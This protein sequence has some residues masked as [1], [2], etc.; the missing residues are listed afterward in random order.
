MTALAGILRFEGGETHSDL[1]RMLKSQDMYGQHSGDWTNGPLSMG[2]RLFRLLPEDRRDLGP[3]IGGGGSLVLVA[4][5]RLDNRDEIAAALGIPPSLQAAMPDSGLLLKGFE[6]WGI[7]VIERLVGDFAIAFWD[8]SRRQLVL[9]RDFL[10]QRPLH[11]HRGRDFFAFASMPKG[12]HALAE[13]PYAPN[14][15]ALTKF[16]A[17]LPNTE[18]YFKGIE[19]VEPGQVVVIT[20]DALAVRSY[21]NPPQQTLRLKDPRDYEAAVRNALDRAVQSR[22]RGAGD[23]V[24][25]QLSAGLDSSA[26]TATAA[27]QLGA[28]ASLVAYTSAPEGDVGR[29]LPHAIADEWPL[30]AATAQLY[31]NITHVR[32]PSSGASPLERLDFYFRIFDRPILNLCNSV[33]TNAILDDARSRGIT[34][35]LSGEVGNMSF[36]Y[37]GMAALSQMLREGRW[38]PLAGTCVSL[39]RGGARV[40]T[41]AAQLIGPNLPPAVWQWISAV[42]G[43][44]RRLSDYTLLNPDLEPAV[45]KWAAETGADISRRPPSDPHASRIRGLRQGDPGN[46]NKGYL[47]GWG[48][49]FRDP[50][51]DRRLV[52]LCLTI[53]PEQ[54]LLGG[55][56]RSLARRAFADRLPAAVRNER[57]KG[58]QAADWHEA[59]NAARSEVTTEL[60][61]CA[62]IPDIRV[63]LDTGRMSQLL[64]EW[65]S[66]GN[67]N[68][69]E[70]I[71]KYRLALLRGTSAAHFIRRSTRA[72]S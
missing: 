48:V 64:E 37:D 63:M 4:D 18:S 56:P 38:G 72:N 17:L 11:Y 13:V 41:V 51:G 67:W 6:A 14:Q 24:G 49:D 22:L 58:Y 59:L 42:R 28:A 21:W 70:R 47:G 34:V 15:R 40:G 30:A 53:P 62:A 68:S 16:L 20:K 69:D 55:V 8:N 44:G 50:T 19:K 45:Q 54:F 65:P 43:K 52:E 10:G 33:W 31:P 9:A 3:Q 23:C 12:L 71:E 27:M 1:R 39:I 46:S 29:G 32:I 60:T 35:M 5:V 66:G 26:V 57:K 61:R 36:S 7:Q 2:R 25:A